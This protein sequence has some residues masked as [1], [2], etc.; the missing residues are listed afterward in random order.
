M[1]M[2]GRMLPT[3][4]QQAHQ[5]IDQKLGNILK[6][7]DTIAARESFP[8]PISEVEKTVGLKEDL[9]KAL[10]QKTMDRKK[11]NAFFKGYQNLDAIW[12]TYQLLQGVVMP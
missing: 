2:P 10:K 1:G 5:N 8:L 9:Q 11:F 7:L 12:Q 4:S 6:T 3:E